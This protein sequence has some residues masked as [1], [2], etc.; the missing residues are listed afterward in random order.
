MSTRLVL[1]YTACGLLFW[2]V[3]LFYWSSVFEAP[4]SD[5]A[6]YVAI[7]RQLLDSWSF[8]SSSFWQTYKPPTIPILMALVFGVVGGVDMDAWRVAQTTLLFASLAWL[9]RE[10]YARTA[11]HFLAASLIVSVSLTR[12]SIFW[13]YK[14]ATESIA[15][16]FVYAVAA[17]L[18][19][20]LRTRRIASAGLLGFLCVAAA[21][22]RPNFAPLMPIAALV[23]AWPAFVTREVELRRGFMALVV[24]AAVA[25]GTWSPWII[26]NYQLYGAL[27]PF[28]TQGPYSFLWEIGTVDVRLDDGRQVRT[29]IH[30]LQRNAA[31]DFPTDQKAAE[32]ANRVVAAWLKANRRAYLKTVPIRM[33]RQ[34][35]DRTEYLTRLPRVRLSGWNWEPL[36]D[37]RPLTIILGYAGFLVFALRRRPWIL[38]VAL[39]LAACWGFGALFL[40]YSRMYEPYTGLTIFG[41]VLLGYALARPFTPFRTH[42]ANERYRPPPDSSRSVPR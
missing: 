16:A 37:K 32:Y 15:E 40:S 22:A 26:R 29:D 2:G 17:A 18:L 5:M 31:T 24:F 27:V 36:A 9:A 8:A 25:A 39:G 30:E 33:W 7:G 12:P 19:W 35:N 11:S 28:T 4:F 42:P 6:D 23:I 14:A 34:V 3:R 21:L 13:S 41:I 1:L 20:N 38:P 10:I